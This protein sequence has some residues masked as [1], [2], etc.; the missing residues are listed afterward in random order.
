MSASALLRRADAVMVI[1][2]ALLAKAAGSG[3]RLIAAG[4]DP[5]AST[6]RGWLCRIVE[7]A[8][9]VLAVL[10]TA[11]ADLGTEFTA[12]ALMP[13]PVAPVVEILRAVTSAVSRWPG[14]WCRGGWPRS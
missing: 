14:E 7:A 5:P 10:A 2:A 9:Q 4:L 11:A 8:E 12:P 13:G 6:V 3:H 1:G